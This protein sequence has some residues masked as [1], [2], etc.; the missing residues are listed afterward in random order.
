MYKFNN[1]T[2]CYITG[3]VLGS[4]AALILFFIQPIQWKG[5][6]LVG[7]GQFVQVQNQNQDQFIEPISTVVARINSRSFINGVAKAAKRD[8]I[9]VLLNSD[10]GA[11]MSVKPIRNGNSLEIII[12]GGS[13]ELVE[14]SLLGVIAQLIE[15]HDEIIKMRKSDIAKEIVK[16]DSE[17]ETLLKIMFAVEQRSTE[18]VKVVGLNTLA[19]QNSFEIKSKRASDLRDSISS[20]N[21][22]PTAIL[23]QPSIT[24]RR[25]FPSLWRLILLCS[26]IGTILSLIWIRWRE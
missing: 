18:G 6:V 16:L 23:E 21:V 4:L 7:I 12:I 13:E 1:K 14:V 24:E 8:E 5:T 25:F 20:L 9:R 17:I 19:A 3:A 10:E 26:L 22:R 2:S 15:K 11:G